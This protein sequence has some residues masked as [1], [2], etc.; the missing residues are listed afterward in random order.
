MPTEQLIRAKAQ[1]RRQEAIARLNG[2]LSDDSHRS[3][4]FYDA[5]EDISI[6]PQEGLWWLLGF[7]SL[8]T[9]LIVNQRWIDSSFVFLSRTISGLFFLLAVACLIALFRRPVEFHFCKNSRKMTIIYRAGGLFRK[10]GTVEFD[11]LKSIQSTLSVTG[12]N[13]PGVSLELMLN[14]GKLLRLKTAPPDWSPT[15]PLLGF[16]GCLEPKELDVIRKKIA[17]LT[18]VEDLG[19]FR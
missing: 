12:D 14:D 13:D 18:G 7:V 11:A 5:A 10:P 9:G 17:A 1:E 3:D 2:E 4:D 8:A 6:R 15:S 19:F 16:S